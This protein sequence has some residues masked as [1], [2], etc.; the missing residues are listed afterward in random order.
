V[1]PLHAH[2]RQ[3]GRSLIFPVTFGFAP[4][5][6]SAAMM[7]TITILCLAVILPLSLLIIALC[8]AVYHFRLK[9]RRVPRERRVYVRRDRGQQLLDNIIRVEPDEFGNRF[10]LYS[11]GFGTWVGSIMEKGP[12]AEQNK[13]AEVSTILE[14]LRYRATT[15]S[16][17]FALLHNHR[18]RVDILRHLI[19]YLIVDR[20]SLDNDPQLTLLPFTPETQV[21]LR[22]FYQFM[23]KQECKYLSL[24]RYEYS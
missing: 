6:H 11:F 15:P 17:F 2:H 5:V 13:E 14:N 24:E 23:H 16:E 19:M 10:S 12:V 4:P 22:A 7:I 8:Y 20:T 18:T 3:L 1:P 21:G 9:A